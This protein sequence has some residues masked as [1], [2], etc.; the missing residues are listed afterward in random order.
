MQLTFSTAKF[1]LIAK[2][3]QMRAGQNEFEVKVD[4][5]AHVVDSTNIDLCLNVFWCTEFY[6]YCL[7]DSFC[8]NFNFRIDNIS[9]TLFIS[10]PNTFW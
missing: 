10:F 4:G 9:I 7:P 6:K 1:G 5:N 2:A 8:T 3:N